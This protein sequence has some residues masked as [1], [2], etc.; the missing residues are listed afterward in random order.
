VD[1]SRVHPQPKTGSEPLHVD[2]EALPFTLFDFWRWS[3]SDLISNATR[4]RLAEFIVATALA[5]PTSRVR[6]EWSPWDLTTPEGITVEVKSAA[7]IQSWHQQRLSDITFGTR[8]SRAWDP[9][10]NQ[11]SDTA[12]RQAQVYIFALLA[13]QEKATVDPLN[14]SQWRFYVLPTA[15]LNARKRS[16]HSITLPSL[17]ALC[18]TDLPYPELRAAVLRAGGHTTAAPPSR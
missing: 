7:Y 5:I 8:K 11:Q 16:Q 3:S 1:L 17:T 2:G 9:Q 12:E 15:V 13:H 14:I 6:D 4:G 10:T 18:G